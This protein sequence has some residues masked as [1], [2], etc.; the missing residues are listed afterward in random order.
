MANHLRVT[1]GVTIVEG[2]AT[3]R[4]NAGHLGLRV[5]EEDGTATQMPEATLVMPGGP[6]SL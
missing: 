4:V 3:F 2:Q 1:D 5:G 6:R